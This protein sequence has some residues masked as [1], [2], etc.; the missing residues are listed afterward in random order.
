[1]TNTPTLLEGLVARQELLT[2]DD[3]YV[4]PTYN[5][6][7]GITEASVKDLVKSVLAVGIHTSVE[8]A[9][10]L[11]DEDSPAAFRLIAGFRRC[12]AAE[13]IR[14]KHDR[15]VRIPANV[16]VGE[17]AELEEAHLIENLHR[18]DLD[19]I[20][21]GRGF[22][23]LVEFGRT[24]A[25]ISRLVGR[26]AGHVAERM[27]F[28]QLPTVLQ[29]AITAGELAIGDAV[30]LLQYDAGHL[31][32]LTKEL[33]AKRTDDVE[34]RQA[35]ADEL[36]ARL[37]EIEAS[38][39]ANAGD[40]S[41]EGR[42]EA[43]KL[44]EVARSKLADCRRLVAETK[45]SF[46]YFDP[47]TMIRDLQTMAYAAK[48]AE[49]VNEFN[50]QMNDSGAAKV[51]ADTYAY[52][53]SDKLPDGWRILTTHE[54]DANSPKYLYLGPD[55]DAHDKLDC[56]GYLVSWSWQGVKVTRC[57]RDPKSHQGKDAPMPTVK[58]PK[59]AGS[60]S[61]AE[62]RRRER[63]AEEKAAAKISAGVE[64]VN[65]TNAQVNAAAYEVL[66]A[67][68]S[69][70]DWKTVCKI[71][72]ITRKDEGAVLDE[73]GNGKRFNP[74]ATAR[75]WGAQSAANLRRLRALVV[76]SYRSWGRPGNVGQGHGGAEV[77]PLFEPPKK[78]RGKA[79]SKAS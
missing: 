64:K 4:D 48:A 46:E 49:L 65:P 51:L 31:D 43:A 66:E 60:S 74:E 70:D 20:D 12:K 45:A 3:I 58:K 55:N 75:A 17:D 44:I 72:G 2:I 69:Q 67:T 52:A 71:L 54:W 25:D 30:E 6:R 7:R 68:M 59:S 62:Q 76:L 14:K 28:L 39:E 42:A 50:E 5:V 32:T 78:K 63:E 1:M 79:T 22:A 11:P 19:P 15:L 57:C 13:V 35:K 73:I 26:S 34:A 24:A 9:P 40:D 27:K 37:A 38:A 47:G 23:R 16:M 33:L 10:R 21:E 41:E 29:Q 8:V 36:E 56:R 18:Q 61:Q 53:V 77:A